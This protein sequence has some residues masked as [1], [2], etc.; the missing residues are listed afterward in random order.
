MRGIVGELHRA[1]SGVFFESERQSAQPGV[2]A[3]VTFDAAG[4][5][6]GPATDGTHNDGLVFKLSRAAD[7]GWTATILHNS[8]I[9]GRT[10]IPP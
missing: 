7:G 10:A 9:T 8:T 6:Y 2:C 1:A 5:L 4:N 3:K